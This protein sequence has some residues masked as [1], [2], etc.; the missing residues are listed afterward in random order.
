MQAFQG[1][2]G[3]RRQKFQRTEDRGQRGLRRM[4]P[5]TSLSSEPLSSEI[6]C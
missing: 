4:T 6:P 3:V 1:T 2:G 5:Q